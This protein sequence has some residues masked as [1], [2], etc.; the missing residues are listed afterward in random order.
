M[1]SFSSPIAE[2][3]K[4]AAMHGGDRRNLS[5]AILAS[6]F[7]VS[8][9]AAVSW[10]IPSFTSLY[11]TWIIAAPAGHP[12]RPVSHRAATR[13][14]PRGLASR[15]HIVLL[16]RRGTIFPVP[17]DPR[18][19]SSVGNC[20]RVLPRTRRRFTS[21]Y[22]LPRVSLACA[23]WTLFGSLIR[24]MR[25]CRVLRLWQCRAAREQ[26]YSF[27][28]GCHPFRLGIPAW[29]AGFF[30]PSLLNFP[31][32]SV[33]ARVPRKCVWSDDYTIRFG[34]ELAIYL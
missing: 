28:R 1:Q 13:D 29:E 22:P 8:L 12:T 33:L 14:S 10:R 2:E 20:A 18:R 7:L 9:L 16:L 26:E 3:E 31:S 4:P 25:A 27:S 24:G 15:Q 34:I 30:D 6:N 19:E 17:S 23:K 5:P 32:R 11:P 21:V